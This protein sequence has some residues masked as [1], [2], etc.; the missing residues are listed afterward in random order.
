MH[1]GGKYD[2]NYA[3]QRIENVFVIV[4]LDPTLRFIGELPI[5]IIIQSKTNG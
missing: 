5:E 2:Y 1:E 3:V 4:L